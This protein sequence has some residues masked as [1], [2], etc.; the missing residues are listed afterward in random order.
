MGNASV[1]SEGRVEEAA[2][3]PLQQMEDAAVAA[4]G[5]QRACGTERG[6]GLEV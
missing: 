4:C 1:L 6:K 2:A 5:R 3:L